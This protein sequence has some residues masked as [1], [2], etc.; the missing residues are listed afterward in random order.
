MRAMVDQ[1]PGDRVLIGETYLPNT[2]DLDKWY[3]GAAHDELQLPMDMLVG[4]SQDAKLTA[5]HFRRYL[6]EAE[7]Q[8]HGSQPLLVFDN[9]DNVRS[10]DR[11]GDGV[12][13]VEIAKCIA[14]ILFTTRA[15]A[16]TYYGAEF[17]MAT[18]PPA[19]KEDVKDPIGITRLA[20]RKGPR[21]RAHAHAVDP[22][23]ASRLLLQSP[24]LA[25]GRAQLQDRQRPDRIR[26]PRLPLE[27]V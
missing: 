22:R 17:G 5:P 13:N 2:A 24:H 16:L 4:F 1:Y 19:R 25:P 3:G 27:L 11:Y 23:P 12:H 18:T 15:T 14:A 7:T 20:Q 21:R 8:L 6:E 26:R 10:I 9:H